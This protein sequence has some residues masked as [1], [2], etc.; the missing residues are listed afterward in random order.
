MA[1]LS[2]FLIFT[3]TVKEI[4]RSCQSDGPEVCVPPPVAVSFEAETFCAKTN[5]DVCFLLNF[6][7]QVELIFMA[8]VCAAAEL[9][10]REAVHDAAGLCASD[11]PAD[12]REIETPKHTR[13]HRKQTS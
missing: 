10:C 9:P 13:R 2:C 1:V 8:P 4:K 5:K 11:V 7:E 6:F 12:V 3:K